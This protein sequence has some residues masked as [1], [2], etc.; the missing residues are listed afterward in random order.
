MYDAGNQL[1][2]FVNEPACLLDGK[3][4]IPVR[5]L[6]D[7]ERD[8]WAEVWEVKIDVTTGLST[9]QDNKVT[10]IQ[11]ASLQK[12]IL[13]LEDKGLIPEWSPETIAK[14]HP[15]R[16]PN[17][18]R[19]LADGIP[20]YT[21]FIDVF[22]DDVSGNRS[23]SWNKHWNVLLMSTHASVPEQFQG[24]KQKI[25]LTHVEPIQTRDALTGQEVKLKIY[26]NC[27]PGDNPAQSEASGHIGSKGNHPCRK[28]N[29]GGSQKEKE[30]NE[31]FHAMFMP[32]RARSS[33]ETLKLVEEQV[34]AACLGVA[35][36]VENMQTATGVKDTFTQ[37][38]IDD[39]IERAR[40]LRKAHPERSAT[41][42][43]EE[44]MAWVL[45][46]KD[47]V[48]NPFLTLKGF[49]VSVDTP[50]EILHTILLGIV[51]YVWH[52]SHTSWN[53]SKKKIYSDR[54]QANPLTSLAT[55]VTSLSVPAIRSSYITQYANSLIGRQLKTLVQVNSFHVYDLVSDLQ[56]ELTK[57]ISELSAL[58]WFVEIRNLEE[59]LSDVEVAAANV[60][61]IAAELDPSKIIAKL[62]YHLLA[63]L[64]KDIIRFGPLVGVATEIFESFNA[65]FRYCSV[66]SNHMAP[67]RDIAYQLSEQE[68]VKFIL[69]GGWWLSE[70]G[71]WQQPGPSV[72][73][74]VAN[75]PVLRKLCGWTENESSTC[76]GSV[77]LETAKRDPINKNK[78][79]LEA[80]TWSKT[81]AAKAINV[82]TT[83]KDAPLLWNRGKHVVAQSQD[84]CKVGSWVY[85]NSP[86]SPKDAPV[87]GKIH[88]ILQD[89][90]STFRFVVL[91]VFSV[92]AHRHEIFGV[93][94]LLRA[95]DE[96]KYILLKAD[97][98]LFSYNVQHDCRLAK[99]TASGNR[100]V[101]QEHILSEKTEAHIEHKPVDRYLVNTH[102][103]HNA[104]LIRATLPRHL[105]IPVPY[106]EDRQAHHIRIAAKL[107]VSQE[108]RQINTAR[109]AEERRKLKG[110]AKKSNKRKRI[111][112]L[113]DLDPDEGEQ[114]D[115]NGRRDAEAMEVDGDN[116]D[117]ELSDGMED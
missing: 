54:L 72:R 50:V 34:H 17:P 103:F 41:D 97:T 86:I 1:H 109:K 70:S 91:D 51:K 23:K 61:D 68:T 67:S 11:A 113:E 14:G 45:K 90:T 107:Q 96:V 6:E 89:S 20:L 42:I 75:Q 105:T 48:Y 10:L 79:T 33:T 28:C 111:S 76:P 36:T 64:R 87:T 58:L 95:F 112:G 83:I 16:M 73:N 69:S 84:I 114:G 85:A 12:N 25:E 9:I 78:T 35:Q 43:Q 65:I 40:N 46:N 115:E 29:V 104:H 5:W 108:A 8:V 3:I 32:D 82:P 60:L 93:P 44:L 100:G 116:V 77:K 106:A 101:M 37:H 80:L 49:N 99:C 13:D 74:Y 117:E 57:A 62:K 18:D 55:N 4:V 7:E 21:S 24:I 110:P 94:T 47:A 53:A 102:A 2:Y 39:L 63:H 19:A 15:S 66:L 81:H 52:G 98:I 31:G 56:F 92:A 22:G 38:W 88:E 30:S 27:A 71:Q 26:C 59:Y